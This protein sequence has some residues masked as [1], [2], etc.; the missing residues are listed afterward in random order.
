MNIST[1][2]KDFYVPAEGGL[3]DGQM[4]GQWSIKFNSQPERGR[5]CHGVA[6]YGYDRGRFTGCGGADHI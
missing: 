3:L 2:H 5:E 4:D 1:W 6:R